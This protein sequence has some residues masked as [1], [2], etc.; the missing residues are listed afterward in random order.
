MFDKQRIE[1]VLTEMEKF[2]YIDSEIIEP[3]NRLLAGEQLEKDEDFWPRMKYFLNVCYDRQHQEMLYNGIHPIYELYVYKRH[4]LFEQPN[5]SLREF[6]QYAIDKDPDFGYWAKFRDVRLMADAWAQHA[7][8][9]GENSWYFRRVLVRMLS[10]GFE[11]DWDSLNSFFKERL[12]WED[13][14]GNQWSLG[15]YCIFHAFVMIGSTNRS[16][17]EKMMLFDL[18]QNK[19]NFLRFLYSAMLERVV[20]CGFI[21]F[22]QISN[23]VKSYS[24]YHPYL[25]LYYPVIMENKDGI[26][27]RGTNR[28]KLEISLEDIRVKIGSVTPSHDLDELCK[29]LFPEK[30]K[31]YID[32]H[33]LKSYREL[34]NELASMQGKMQ[35]LINKQVKMLS[36]SAIP[37]EVIASELDKLSKSVPGMAYEVFEKLNSLLIADKVWT[38]NAPE[39][40]N[41]ILERMQHP[42]IQTT[43]YYAAGAQHNDNQKHLH[44][45]NDHKQIGQK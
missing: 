23:Q 31:Q 40:R 22:L 10:S 13:L 11:A 29:I 45:T 1:N 15:V 36:D 44:L 42:S 9:V 27:Q 41:R 39:I 38:K 2:D 7:R 18:F 32:K 30:L 17:K 3:L 34:E 33:R 5:S 14:E 26:C 28:E 43:N 35:E 37:V 19:W 21:N 20:G 12:V 16:P 6:I 25:H 8:K 4:K 24:D